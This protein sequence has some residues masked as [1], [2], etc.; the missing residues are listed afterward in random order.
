MAKVRVIYKSGAIIDVRCK[1]FKVVRSFG[2]ISQIEW[3]GA[4]PDALHMGVDE[5]AAVWV[6]KR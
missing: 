5:V 2:G 1:N 3:E 4:K 6:L